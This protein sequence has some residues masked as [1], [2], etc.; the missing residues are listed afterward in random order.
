MFGRCSPVRALSRSGS[1]I[2]AAPALRAPLRCRGM[3]SL[4]TDE[5]KSYY[6]LGVNV[7]HQ[8]DNGTLTDVSPA[9]VEAIAAGLADVLNKS[10]LQL[11]VQEFG[12]TA[13]A[14]FSEKQEAAAAEANKGQVAYLEAAVA[15]DGA[16]QTESGLVIKETLAGEGDSPTAADTVEVRWRCL[17]C[18]HTL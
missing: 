14:F 4:T 12:A 11:D 9:D 13:A 16:T 18:S 15:E 1:A 7:A 3:A 8:L 17:P 10:E 2:R 5:L 6:C